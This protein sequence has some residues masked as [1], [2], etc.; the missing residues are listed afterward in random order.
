V[1]PEP[2]TAPETTTYH[3]FLP[4]EMAHLANTTSV[5]TKIPTTTLPPINT[6]RMPEANPNLPSGY[7]A[8]NPLLNVP[9]PTPPKTPT[10]SPGG[11]PFPG[12]S[13]PGFIPT[14]P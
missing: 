11:P 3:F 6:Q 9:H 14:L 7:H 13:I 8:L 12:H 2:E 10:D 4:P 5:Q 1:S